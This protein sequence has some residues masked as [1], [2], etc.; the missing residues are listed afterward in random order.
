MAKRTY[1]RLG[2]I[3]HSAATPLL[4]VYMKGQRRVRVLVVDEKDEVLLVRSWFG[5]QRW[6]LPGGGIRRRESPAAAGARE[7][8]EET[9][10]II[11]ERKCQSLGEF[12]NHDS[13]APFIIDCQKVII[14]KQPAHI[15][16]RRRLEMLD[17]AWFSIKHLPSRRSKTVDNALKLDKK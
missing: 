12:E 15:A 11:D 4:K 16:A 17:V 3:A 9:G 10:V 13:N 7:V 14:E 2:R 8:F 5:H 1:A 6:S